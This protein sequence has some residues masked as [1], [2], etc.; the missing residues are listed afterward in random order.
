MGWTEG[1]AGGCAVCR[2]RHCGTP[3]TLL[4]VRKIFEQNDIGL[5]F[6]AF[7]NW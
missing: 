1:G 5:D 3:P 2:L 6:A 4:N 7:F